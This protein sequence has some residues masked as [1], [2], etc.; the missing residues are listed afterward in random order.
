MAGNR[1]NGLFNFAGNF[2]PQISSPLDARTTVPTQA[3]L[4]L[5][6]TWVAN[7]GGT[8]TY[9]GMTVTV[10]EDSTSANNGVYIL[11]DPTAITNLASWKFVGSGSGQD[12]EIKDDGTSITTKVKDI[13]FV[14]T[15]VTV[16]G[17]GT[18]NENITV[19]ISGG[20]GSYT[21]ATPTPQNFPGNSPFDNIPTGETFSNET[22]EAMMNKMLY[23]TI[24][25]TLTAPSATLTITP[26]ATYQEIGANIP[27]TLDATFNQGL[28]NPQY[29]SASNKRS[30]L[31]NTYNFNGTGVSPVVST[32]LAE[33]AT[34]GAYTI[35]A[36]ANTWTNSVS[37]DAGV[38]PKDSVGGDFD[39]PGA[40]S[41]GTTSTISRTITGVYPVFANTQIPIGPPPN[42]AVKQT[43]QSMTTTIVVDFA[44]ELVSNPSFYRQALDIPLA[45]GGQVGWSTITAVE[46][47]NSFSGLWDPSS[48][49]DWTTSATTHTIQ[50]LVINYTRYTYNGPPIGG[51][52]MRFKT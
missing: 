24:N 30:G 34:T 14:G 5:A 16:T 47:F 11:L 2:E 43:L 27:V 38:M 35:L 39:P 15:G 29:T 10:A 12:I 17:G 22:F 50:G 49:S 33:S 13:D 9:V 31:P 28:I 20:L 6:N 3:D 26:G 48:L 44:S 1:T 37:F 18:G 25:P 40:L 4:L 41:A 36:G 42:T 23:P 51:R 46:Q 52:K 19:T 7:D 8:Y 45:G 32:S 21:N